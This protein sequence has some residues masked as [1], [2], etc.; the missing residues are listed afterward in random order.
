MENKQKNID[1]DLKDTEEQISDFQRE[2]MAKLNQLHVAI[3]LKVKQIQNLQANG[4]C[5]AK[6]YTL[7]QEQLY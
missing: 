5:V 7:R 3:V 6:W 4:E 2:K 1:A